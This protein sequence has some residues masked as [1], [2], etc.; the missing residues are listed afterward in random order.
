MT[1][2]AGLGN[3]GEKY[4]N[5]RHNIGARIVRKLESLELEN[6]ILS[7]PKTFMNESGKGIRLLLKKHKVKTSDL[8]LIHDDI[9]LPMGKLK[10]VKGR[11]SAGHKGVESTIKELGKNDFIRFRIGIRPEGGKPKNFENFVLQKFNKTEENIL[12]E[13]VEKTVKAV[14]FCLK[15]G[16]E[17]TMGEFNK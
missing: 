3:P 8:W 2:I 11:G 16:S 10:I 17:K 5:T 1:I 6:V 13:V 12:K 14:E 9:D 7:G 4:E 15:E